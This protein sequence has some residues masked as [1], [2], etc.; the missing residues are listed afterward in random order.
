MPVAATV[1]NNKGQFLGGNITNWQNLG[2]NSI[3]WS[4]IGTF[5]FDPQVM[6][7]AGFSVLNAVRSD[8][9][10]CQIQ[11]LLPLIDGVVCYTNHWKHHSSRHARR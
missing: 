8:G 4:G 6:Q 5:E 1:C 2:T 9:T 3:I 11:R 10:I 7:T